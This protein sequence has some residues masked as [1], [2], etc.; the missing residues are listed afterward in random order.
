MSFFTE[1]LKRMVVDKYKCVTEG[2]NERKGL[3]NL[4][5]YSR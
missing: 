1:D 2:M 4:A 5:I 3:M